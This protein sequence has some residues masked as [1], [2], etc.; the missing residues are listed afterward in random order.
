MDASIH[1][2]IS[3][4]SYISES[5]IILII[6]PII[7]SYLISFHVYKKQNKI[8]E[9]ARIYHD[10]RGDL[11]DLNKHFLNFQQYYTTRASMLSLYHNNA[12]VPGIE[13]EIENNESYLKRFESE[14]HDEFHKLSEYLISKLEKTSDTKSHLLDKEILDGIRN[15]TQGFFITEDQDADWYTD[16]RI[17]QIN[18]L[19]KKIETKLK[20]CF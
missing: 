3:V 20:K 7:I 11:Y 14:S 8:S 4:I 12:G 1:G 16:E 18:K 6:I 2:T 13:E 10:L 5:R 17:E 15:F 9:K 19:C